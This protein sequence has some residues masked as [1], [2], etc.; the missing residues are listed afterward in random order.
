MAF[1]DM[2]STRV[3]KMRAGVKTWKHMLARV[4]V[5]CLFNVPCVKAGGEGNFRAQLKRG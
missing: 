4:L 2:A 5:P 3:E 1:I